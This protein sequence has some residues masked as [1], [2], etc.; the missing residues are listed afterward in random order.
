MG[1]VPLLNVYIC[2]SIHVLISVDFLR[3]VLEI[4]L[5]HFH[6]HPYADNLITLANIIGDCEEVPTKP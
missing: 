4:F 5:V 1:H 6:K 2:L 3:K